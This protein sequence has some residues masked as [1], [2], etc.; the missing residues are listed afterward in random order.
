MRDLSV[1]PAGHRVFLLLGAI[2]ILLATAMMIAVV[3]FRGY[4]RVF[5]NAHEVLTAIISLDGSVTRAES[6]ARAYLLTGE[7]SF[8]HQFNEHRTVVMRDRELLASLVAENSDE[9]LSVLDLSSAVTRG[10]DHLSEMTARRASDPK[11][12]A[13]GGE[14][15][16][17]GARLESEINRLITAARTNQERSLVER[18]ER[19]RRIEIA[20]LTLCA[21]G[22]LVSF[23]L[24]L[25]GMKAMRNELRLRD[26]AEEELRKSNA[27]LEQKVLDRTASI[28]KANSE[29]QRS[30]KELAAIAT[31]LE[32]SNVE[33][34]SFA[35]AATHDLQEP[36][37]TITLFAQILENQ[38]REAPPAD[39]AYYLQT[40]IG[41]A[42]RMTALIVGMLEY[43]KVSREPF[44]LSETVDLNEVLAAVQENLSAQI[45]ASGARITP[46]NLPSLTGSRL[47]LIRL[48]QNL[49]GNSIKYRNPDRAC[50]I[51]IQAKR[52]GEYWTIS[53]RDNGLGFK[54]EYQE[55][56]F[57]LFKRL[58]RARAGA[59]VG[60]ATCQTIVER[61]GGRIWAESEEGRGAT[62][63]FTWPSAP[64]PIATE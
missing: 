23:S 55:Y 60:L 35:Y 56:V 16:P 59:G 30:Q 62:F 50:R 46:G 54:P 38:T 58:D 37:R 33:L 29:L 19:R 64:W 18:R 63:H 15:D 42:D 17:E 10:M 26:Q 36:L 3:R 1:A 27:E 11:V 25:V 31:A 45:S 32:R 34:E 53:V 2:T 6:S 8:L 61:Y 22:A 14:H 47:Q 39:T 20:V 44:E 24:V 49:I 9:K 7:D 48:M 52:D 28:Q 5:A 43:S 41:A 57:G 12:I 4:S 40:I 13:I 21:M 51:E